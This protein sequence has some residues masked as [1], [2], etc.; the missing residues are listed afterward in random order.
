MGYE[1]GHLVMTFFWDK[2]SLQALLSKVPN[3]KD[4]IIYLETII[5]NGYGIQNTLEVYDGLEEVD[6]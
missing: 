5:R 1:G 6:F 3:D 2:K 4:V